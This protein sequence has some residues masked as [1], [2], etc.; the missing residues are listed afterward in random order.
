VSQAAMPEP[1]AAADPIS[2]NALSLAWIFGF[3]REVG[4]HNLCD[5]NRSAIFYA[6]AH[7][8]IIYDLNAKTQKLLQGHCNAISC[9]CASADRRLVA[10]ADIGDDSMLVLWDSYTASPVKTIAAPHPGGVRAMDISPDG[11]H[12]VTLSA[13]TGPQVLSVWDCSRDGSSETPLFSAQV[14]T[15]TGAVAEVQTSVRLDPSNPSE[16]VTNGASIVIFWS[17]ATGVLTYYSPPLG[18]HDFKQPIGALTQSVFIPGSARAVTATADGDAVL[19]DCV[20]QGPGEPTS[21]RCASK[22]V[23]LH[24]G[25]VNHLLTTGEYLVSGGHDGYVRF[26]DF[27]FRIIAWFEDIDAGPVA[28][29][30]FAVPSALS[31]KAAQASSVLACSDFVVGTSNALIV[32]CTPSM[33]DELQA[34][35]RRGALLVQ[36][37]DAM[38]HGL[39]AHPSLSRF[40]VTG[41]AGLLQLWDYSEKRLLLMRMFEKLLG[42]TLAFSPNGK[43]LAIGFT[44]GQLKV[45]MGMTLEELATFK[46]SK[47]CITAAAFSNC[48]TFLATA[49]TDNCIGVYRLGN[50]G[51]DAAAKKE[52]V[53]I[54]KYRGHYKPVTG[55][56]FGEGADGTP[57]LFS[58]GEDRSLVE[59]DLARSSVQGGIQLRNTAKVEQTAVCTGCMWLPAG[60]QGA[61]PVVVTANDQ[62]KLRV[63]APG[64]KSIQRTVIGPTYGGPL[65]RMLLLPE[66]D[67]GASSSGVRHVAYATHDKVIG[68]MQMPMD[69]NPSRVMGLISHPGEVSDLAVSWDGKH[70]ITAG[71]ADN[72]IHLWRTD[73]AA[74]EAATKAG[75]AGIEPF[76]AQLEGG[77]EGSFY[78]EMIDHFYYAQLRAQGED[79]TDPR[80]I[81]RLVP[82]KQLGN[83]MRSLG[84]Y[85]SQREVDEITLEARLV[86]KEAVAKDPT[87]TSD[88]SLNFDE[89][90]TMYVNHRPIFGVSKEQIADAFSVLSM[91]GQGTLSRDSLLRAL[92]S[93]DESLAGDDLAQCLRMLVGVDDPAAAI[94]DQIDA[95]TFAEAILG[96]QDYAAA[97]A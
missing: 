95:K 9:T 92:A 41:R 43:F 22:V 48:S 28:S 42:H 49:D 18:E 97:G 76:V 30:S 36:G 75:G 5:D 21:E 26:F 3:S 37:Q 1:S 7:T 77:A 6:S 34:E 20:E 17:F 57:R 67:E 81:S 38:V 19:W 52:W 12:L 73:V 16:I 31:K 44:N 4:L 86:A 13:D 83:M 74:L 78:Q 59:Y 47:G 87:R 51:D 60:V 65:T 89:F 70:V 54:G 10:T 33:F 69:G 23:R 35:R 63:V 80:L 45:L 90:L 93:H 32:A 50:P 14:T 15:A 85:P 46:A 24:S 91:D 27:D 84:F 82:I 56:Q 29:V 58:S 88:D 66:G 2:E 68:L 62:Y 64:P 8:G 25:A 96:F 11:K 72:S 79:T 61:E 55:I 39:A 53:Y 71:G 40:A 94:P